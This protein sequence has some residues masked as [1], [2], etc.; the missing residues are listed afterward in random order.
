MFTRR[1]ERYTRRWGRCKTLIIMF[2]LECSYATFHVEES[3]DMEATIGYDK[4]SEKRYF[5]IERV[6]IED[7]HDFIFETEIGK[8]QK[9]ISLFNFSEVDLGAVYKALRYSKEEQDKCI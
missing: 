8:I 7:R 5:W 1:V 4:Y 9:L 6:F 3:M 2:Q